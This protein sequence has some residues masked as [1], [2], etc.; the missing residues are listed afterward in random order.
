MCWSAEPCHIRHYRQVQ[1]RWRVFVGPALFALLSVQCGAVEVEAAGCPD[2]TEPTTISPGEPTTI[3]GHDFVKG[4]CGPWSPGCASRG[5]VVYA[6][7]ITLT[8]EQGESSWPLAT[9]DAKPDVPLFVEVVIPNEIEPGEARVVAESPD[10]AEP[11]ELAVQ[12]EP[13]GN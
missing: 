6:K 10:L 8:L 7:N 9:V 11:E 5:P 2:L 1:G 4:G 12:V 13:S 3:I